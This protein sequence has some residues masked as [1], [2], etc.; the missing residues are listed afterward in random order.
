MPRNQPKRQLSLVDIA[1]LE[2]QF[3]QLWL[4][5]HGARLSG[6]RLWRALGFGSQRA[7]H[8]ALQDGWNGV[9]LTE[10]PTRRGRWARTEEVAKYVWKEIRVNRLGGA[11]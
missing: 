1:R 4:E 6:E 2:A 5:R 3:V 7:F 8:R 11:P 9:A 10:L